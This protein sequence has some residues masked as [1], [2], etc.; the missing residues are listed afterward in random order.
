M[1]ITTKP[2]SQILI[3]PTRMH[4]VL[5]ADGLK[6]NGR[7]RRYSTS[8]FD[9]VRVENSASSVECKVDTTIPSKF[10][11]GPSTSRLVQPRDLMKNRT[12]AIAVDRLRSATFPMRATKAYKFESHIPPKTLEY[13][14]EKKKNLDLF[15][16][17]D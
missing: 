4:G 17:D 11:C 15:W 10:A 3:A 8:E 16:V 1:Y 13:I 9:P 14:G 12:K 7:H 6:S 5:A 2:A